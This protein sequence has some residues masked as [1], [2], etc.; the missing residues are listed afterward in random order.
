MRIIGYDYEGD[1]TG[2]LCKKCHDRF[3]K[4]DL[5]WLDGADIYPIDRDEMSKKDPEKDIYA[6][7]GECGRTIWGKAT[8]YA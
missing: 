4:S 7:C 8:R 5:N 3:C 2:T 1:V 6:D